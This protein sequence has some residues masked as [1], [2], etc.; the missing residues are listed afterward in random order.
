MELVKKKDD[1]KELTFIQNI[2][3]GHCDYLATRVSIIINPQNI[4][5]SISTFSKLLH[6]NWLKVETELYSED[7]TLNLK[8]SYQIDRKLFISKAEQTR[9][10][11]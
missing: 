9:R 10:V 8:E 6:I 5:I 7:R 1:W 4:N 3:T 2:K 11:L